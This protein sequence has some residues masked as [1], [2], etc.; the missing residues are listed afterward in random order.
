MKG[1]KSFTCWIP[2]ELH[3]MLKKLSVET[4]TSATQIF[5]KYLRYLKN[6]HHKKRGL[7]DEDSKEKF[8]F[9]KQDS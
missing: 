9:T 8:D 5:T 4:Q 1:M 7:L 6:K 2:E 3:W